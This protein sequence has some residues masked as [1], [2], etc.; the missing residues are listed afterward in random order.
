MDIDGDCLFCQN[1]LEDSDNLFMRCCFC[2]RNL[3]YKVD[4]CHVPI[5]RNLVFID[6]FEHV[7]KKKQRHIINYIIHL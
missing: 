2:S 6:W 5:R 4:Y 1:H 7:W 3:E